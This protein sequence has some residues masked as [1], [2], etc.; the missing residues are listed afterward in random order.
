MNRLPET[1]RI[2]G[3]ELQANTTQQQFLVGA[4]TF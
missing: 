3:E 2:E 1:A 4:G